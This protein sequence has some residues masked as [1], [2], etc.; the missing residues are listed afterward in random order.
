MPP[1]AWIGS[2]DRTDDVAVGLGDRE[3]GAVGANDRLERWQVIR[4][5][6]HIDERGVGVERAKR[7]SEGS[8]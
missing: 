3:R 7:F 1:S 6:E 5:L 4:R 2:D 8:G